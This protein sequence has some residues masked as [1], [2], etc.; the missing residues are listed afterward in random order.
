[1]NE[2]FIACHLK[3]SDPRCIEQ[4]LSAFLINEGFPLLR[5][6]PLREALDADAPGHDPDGTLGVVLS[7]AAGSGWVSVY[8][9]DW[10]ESGVLAKALSQR[11]SLW[12]LELWVVNDLH[13]GYTLYD[14]GQVLDR[15]A[16]NPKNVADTRE[17]QAL[18]RGN[19]ALFLPL[20]K[21][22]AAQVAPILSRAHAQA[23]RFAAEPIDALADALG[24]P[25]AHAFLGYDSFFENDPEDYADDLEHWPQFRHLTFQ[26]PAGR[27]GLAE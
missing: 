22:P 24:L 8:T 17:E 5:A 27:E 7:S 3:T 21:S 13:W 15:F 9:A 10:L 18:Y 12:A 25:F 6:E 19:P 2:S 26:I 23:G 14:S 20:L 1:M 16:D 11:L 4:D